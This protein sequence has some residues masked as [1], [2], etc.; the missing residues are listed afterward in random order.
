MS[1][2]A[3]VGIG[4]STLTILILFITMIVLPIIPIFMGQRK[5]TTAMPL[6]GASSVVISAACHVPV[7]DEDVG[8]Q[9]GLQKSLRVE[10][11]S[12]EDDEDSI[13]EMVSLRDAAEDHE[14]LVSINNHGAGNETEE[15]SYGA[16]SEEVPILDAQDYLRE[17]ARNPVRWGAVKVP[18]SWTGPSAHLNDENVAVGH[19][20]FGTELHNVQEPVPGQLYA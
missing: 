18:P 20:S 11:R 1:T 14:P 5:F 9:N 19:L 12:V 8:S 2:D 13:Y 6:A 16:R 3:Y 15:A 17:V 7:L 4:Y 10:S